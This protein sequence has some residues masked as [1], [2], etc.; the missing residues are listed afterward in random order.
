MN[1]GAFFVNYILVYR[2]YYLLPLYL[3]MYGG[4]I[5]TFDHTKVNC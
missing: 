4:V 1:D 3:P 2:N 5:Y